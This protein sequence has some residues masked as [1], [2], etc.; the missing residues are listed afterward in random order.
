MKDEFKKQSID[1]SSIDRNDP[2]R[3]EDADKIQ[4][5]I[6]G[7]PVAKSG[8]LRT[9]VNDQFTD[10][11][12]TAVNSTDYRLN[13]KQSEALRLKSGHDDAN[14]SHHRAQDQR[15]GIGGDHRGSHRPQQRRGGVAGRDAWCGRPG[16][17]QA[18]SPDSG[19]SR[20]GLKSR[21]ARLHHRRKREPKHGGVLPLNTKLVPSVA[22]GGQPPAWYVV[23]RTPIVRG[24][25]IRDAHASQGEMGRWETNFVLTQEAAKRFQRYTESN[26]GNRAAIVVDGQVISAPTIQSAISD[27]GRITGAGNQ[28]EASD[29]GLNL[30]AGSLPAGVVYQ[31]ERTVG[32]SLGRR[33]HPGRLPGGYRRLDCGR[34]LACW[35]IIGEPA[36]TLL[37]LWS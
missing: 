35:S 33:L 22:R 30:R 36:S 4:I 11:V 6:K 27:T 23:S 32:P 26:I 18:A 24:T 12:L 1:F 31:E 25:D 10:W 14:H 5:D 8:A 19:S 34:G 2:G 16:S 28:E 37:W 20:V 13:M 17:R 3:I 21:T 29:L 15:P 9:L 7:V